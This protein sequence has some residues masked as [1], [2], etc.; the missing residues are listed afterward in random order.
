MSIFEIVGEVV[1]AFGS[2]R[3]FLCVAPVLVG[4]L[5][6]HHAYPEASWTWYVSVPALVGALA[7]GCWWEWRANR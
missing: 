2:W 1:E 4:A 6:L 3:L 7:G 5:L